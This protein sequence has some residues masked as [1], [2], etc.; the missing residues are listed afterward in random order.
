MLVNGYTRFFG[1]ADYGSDDVSLNYV[2]IWGHNTYIRYDYHATF[3]YYDRVTA[4]PLILTE[5]GVDAYDHGSLREDQRSQAEWVAHE[6]EQVAKGC[7]GGAVMEYCDEWW[8]FTAGSP[9]AHEP[10]GYD[11]DVQPDG[12]SDEEWYGIMAVER[13]QASIDIL[14]PREVFGA[15]QQAY[16]PRV[17]GDIDSD[18]QVGFND[19]ALLS[20]H[21]GQ[22]DCHEDP[23]CE[24]T[25]LDRD[26]QITIGDLAILCQHWLGLAQ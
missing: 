3:C 13:G 20:A 1:D 8:K 12:R 26:G 10:G 4:K 9:S 22:P 11:T 24:A 15:L 21:W 7:L 5:F 25:D 23:Q 14:Q 18:G 16:A 2:D 17:A 19:F 6:W